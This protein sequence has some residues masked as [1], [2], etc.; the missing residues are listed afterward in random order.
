[1]KYMKN[2]K[3]QVAIFVIIAIAIVAVV[4]VVFLFPKIDVFGGA[5]VNPSSYLSKC[6]EPEVEEIL[7]VVTKQGGYS[8]PFVSIKYMDEDIQYLC[9]NAEEYEPCIVQQP[10]LVNHVEGEIKD[11]IEP[12]AIKCMDE[13]KSEYE[14]KGYRVQAGS[15]EID[16]DIVPG[17]IA[18]D[19][20]SPMTIERE[21][22]TQNFEKFAIGL[23]SE[24]YNLLMTA[25]SIID[26]ESTLGDSETTL[27]LQYYP[28]LKIDKTRR[29]DGSTI[30]KL[31]NVVTGDE[32]TFATRS[33][34]WPEGYGL[35]KYYV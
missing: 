26:F 17:S 19:F 4:L 28:D 10:L 31:S 18:I 2:E 3:G 6:V 21:G 33:L 16:V 13:L 34:I 25:V 32:F 35:E 30:Y 9:Y 22:N 14:R 15:G 27:Y 1:M 29:D 5:D 8:E 11:Y 20:I 7:D 24:L 23:D 12:K